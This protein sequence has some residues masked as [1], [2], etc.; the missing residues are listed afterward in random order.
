MVNTGRPTIQPD[1]AIWR[2]LM[3]QSRILSVS[4]PCRKLTT[5]TEFR[6]ARWREGYHRRQVDFWFERIAK[7]RWNNNYLGSL[8]SRMIPAC[9]TRF[10]LFWQ[11]VCLHPENYPF[12]V[13]IASPSDS[14][15][16]L[17]SID[18]TVE[19][20]VMEAWLVHSAEADLHVV[21]SRLLT[22]P[23]SPVQ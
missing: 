5:A 15:W 6:W 10:C 4:H 7:T 19:L 20:E 17:S 12:R 22:G 18:R 9:S 21:T 13:Q 11:V 23:L 1:V 8:R 16:M 2:F 3:A 14:E